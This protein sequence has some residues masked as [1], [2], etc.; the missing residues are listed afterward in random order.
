MID[1]TVYRQR[2]VAFARAGQYGRMRELPVAGLVG[3][4]SYQIRAE[5]LALAAKPAEEF[6]P[7]ALKSDYYHAQAKRM[8]PE[9]ARAKLL[10]MRHLR[11]SFAKGYRRERALAPVVIMDGEKF[12]GR[13]DGTHR[14]CAAR[15]FGHKA[16]NALVV[17]PD[18][19]SGFL[20]DRLYGRFR[21]W[22]QPIEIKPGLSTGTFNPAKQG[23]LLDALPDMNGASVVDI[24]CNSGLYS[25]ECAKR[26][27]AVVGIDRRQEAI[28]QAVFVRSVWGARDSRVFN[29]TFECGSIY[30]RLD[31]FTKAG[32][33]TV[34]MCCVV[35]HLTDGLH[36]VLGAIRD[37]G[38]RRII[39]QGNMRR[40]RKFK[41]GEL[42]AA[43]A[44]ADVPAEA[45]FDLPRF[46]AL[47]GRYGFTPEAHKP[48]QFPVGLYVR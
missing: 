19:W 27:A 43:R 4:V 31:M 14:I 47:F 35:Y 46:D 48:G 17:G 3:E 9:R 41:P 29:A 36:R 26:G 11:Q 1:I 23:A 24:G 30:D 33:D 5:V 6:L 34:L 18:E 2:F 12:V 22:Y 37:S 7:E 38:V 13:L 15:F 45:I 44:Q 8:G 21:K 28:D 40:A 10:A 20:V 39:V 32:P 25:L 42:D 16:V